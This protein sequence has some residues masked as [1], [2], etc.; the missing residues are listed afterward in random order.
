MR[1]NLL[2]GQH[3]VDEE[4][5]FDALA[6]AGLKKY[7][8]QLTRFSKKLLV[9]RNSGI[10]LDMDALTY[11]D[12]ESPVAR[13][14]LVVWGVGLIVLIFVCWAAFA[15]LDEIV[16][17]PG[18]VVPVSNTQIIQSLEGGILA[19]LNV[20]EGDEIDRGEVVA[21]LSDTRYKGA[22]GELK[23][24]LSGLELKRLRLQAELAGQSEFFAPVELA[25]QA[26]EVAGS[27]EALFAARFS[28]FQSQV[29]SLKRS[30]DL[31]YYKV[32]VEL[33]GT[34]LSGSKKS[35]K[36]RPGMLAEAE[37]RVGEKTVLKYLL[38]PLFKAS[39][40]F[41]EP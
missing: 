14:R 32:T 29:Q 31:H 3:Q 11:V 22:H 28:A 37:L 18:K 38:K 36:I 24:Q 10:S 12:A 41:R 33:E 2:V 39:E 27:E 23:N 1:D 4:L 9:S 20:C 40:S 26:P 6:F 5:L 13:Y 35:V 21:R 7:V 34:Q 19:E 16:R 8:G 25:E 15:P 30:I 17:G